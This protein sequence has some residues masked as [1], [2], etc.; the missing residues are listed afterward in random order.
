MASVARVNAATTLSP[1]PCSTGRAPPAAATAWARIS[2]WEAIAPT[3]SS[4]RSCHHRVELS[5]SVSKN[6]TVPDG[7]EIPWLGV[8]APVSTRN[9]QPAGAPVASTATA[10]LGAAGQTSYEGRRQL[11]DAPDD[12]CVDDQVVRL[13]VPRF[14]RRQVV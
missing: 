13:K 2:A 1:S 4:G 12:R 3:I 7:N 5:T 11:P 6:V 8:T 9:E 10:S 14:G